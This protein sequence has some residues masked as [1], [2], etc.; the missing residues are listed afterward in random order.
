MIMAGTLETN[1][2]NHLALVYVVGWDEEGPVK[3]GR[4][5]ALPMRLLALQTGCPYA[6]KVFCT[7]FVAGRPTDTRSS[8]R[9]CLNSGSVSLE[10]R[11]HSTLRGFDLQLTGEWF[12]IS[13]RDA[14]AVLDKVT[15]NNGL[16]A[17]GATELSAVDLRGRAD[18]A[19][20]KAYLKLAH[21]A[22][23]INTFVKSHNDRAG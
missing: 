1:L 3:I 8:M 12:D 7:R 20:L 17:V 5:T 11:A 22:L 15:I 6:L 21:E 10:K 13:A 2:D 9:H 16:R 19:M 18:D 14:I 23:A 4:T